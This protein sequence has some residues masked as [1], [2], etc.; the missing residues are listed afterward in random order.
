MVLLKCV[1][2]HFTFQL[3]KTFNTETCFYMCELHYVMPQQWMTCLWV[4]TDMV[5]IHS[6]RRGEN[7][8]SLWVYR[9]ITTDCL[10]L[11]RAG[12]HKFPKIWKQP[13]NSGHQNDDMTQVTY[14]GP[15]NIRHHHSKFSCLGFLHPWVMVRATWDQRHIPVLLPAL[16]FLFW[17]FTARNES[18]KS[19]CNKNLLLFL[20]SNDLYVSFAY[21]N[22]MC[23]STFHSAVHLLL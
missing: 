23:M 17:I 22:F 9:Y 1:Y 2:F 11:I 18:V 21:Y 6:Y 8:H 13:Q 19:N 16:S 7:P 5:H 4:I 3:L 15:T 12:V 20:N 10:K 14:W